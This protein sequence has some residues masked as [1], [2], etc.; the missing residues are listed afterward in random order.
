MLRLSVLRWSTDALHRPTLFVQGVTSLLQLQ[1][2][3]RELP[4]DAVDQRD[5]VTQR[6]CRELEAFRPAFTMSSTFETS[7]L[8]TE[9][10]LRMLRYFGLSQDPMARSL[11]L[12]LGR[13]AL[14]Q[15]R[16][17]TDMVDRSD[18]T[19]N[20]ARQRGSHH[21]HSTEIGKGRGKD[22][23]Q[24]HRKSLANRRGKHTR[25]VGAPLVSAPKEEERTAWSKMP[26]VERLAMIR[27]DNLTGAYFGELSPTELPGMERAGERLA[28]KVNLH[29]KYRGH[30]VLREPEIAMDKETR[31]SDPW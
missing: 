19:I 16:P 24:H 22:N 2:A 17:P 4:S 29:E 27:P 9:S 25:T 31:R 13:K 30:W 5:D 28:G 15:R 26:V 6:F 21:H 11:E 1:K 20:G 8:Y 12:S 18:V 3:H 14:Q 7:S 23:K 10:L